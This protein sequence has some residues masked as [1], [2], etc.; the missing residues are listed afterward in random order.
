MD[1]QTRR[2][3]YVLS[4]RRGKKSVVKFVLGAKEVGVT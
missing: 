1:G 4:N 3:S 2:C